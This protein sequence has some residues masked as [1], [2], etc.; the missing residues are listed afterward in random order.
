MHPDFNEPFAVL[1]AEQVKYL[2]VGGYAVLL[3]AQPTTSTFSLNRTK[4]MLPFFSAR[5]PNSRHNVAN[6]PSAGLTSDRP[7]DNNRL[8]RFEIEDGIWRKATWCRR[9][10]ANE[11]RTLG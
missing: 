8:D 1:N 5:W 9:W 4:R 7:D 2:A 6:T 3:H 11:L 10:L